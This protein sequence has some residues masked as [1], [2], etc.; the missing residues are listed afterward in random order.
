VRGVCLSVPSIVGRAGVERHVEIKLWPKEV[1]G[2]QQSA[3]AL[4]ET[5]S[6][7]KA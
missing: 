6:K 2:V 7:V 3:R 4:G 5:L 1:A